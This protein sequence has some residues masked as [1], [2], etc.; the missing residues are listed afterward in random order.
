MNCPPNTQTNKT[1]GEEKELE[2][3]QLLEIEIF[4][5]LHND[6]SIDRNKIR[7]EL[8]FTFWLSGGHFHIDPCCKRASFL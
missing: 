1:A 8:L 2:W 6:V 7:L 4:F 3:P 5:L